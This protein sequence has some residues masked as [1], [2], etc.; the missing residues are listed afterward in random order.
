M[1]YFAN[2]GDNDKLAYI[3]K[4]RFTFCQYMTLVAFVVTSDR[5]LLIDTTEK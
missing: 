2:N 5:S 3:N 4:T 1:Y